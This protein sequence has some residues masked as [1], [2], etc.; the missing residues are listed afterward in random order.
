[1]NR[2]SLLTAILALPVAAAVGLKK[3]RL[4]LVRLPDANIHTTWAGVVHPRARNTGGTYVAGQ[5][6]TAADMNA[7][8]HCQEL[9][10]AWIATSPAPPPPPSHPM[11]RCVMG[12]VS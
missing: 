7:C 11:C 1:M 4:P 5:T 12:L 9:E 2:R 10:L 6:L 3:K 8:R